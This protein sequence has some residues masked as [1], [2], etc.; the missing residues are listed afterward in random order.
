[1]LDS[2]IL[3]YD[4]REE[5]LS[6][7]IFTLEKVK[8]PESTAIRVNLDLLG[9]LEVAAFS[10]I[11]AAKVDFANALFI[12]RDKNEVAPS[13]LTLVAVDV[14]HS[15]LR[16][17]LFGGQNRRFCG[18]LNT[19]TVPPGPSG[20]EREAISPL[21]P[22]TGLEHA[23]EARQIPFSVLAGV[24]ESRLPVFFG[25]LNRA[26]HELALKL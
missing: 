2:E 26:T 17:E 18:V 23:A 24:S 6:F 1:M 13:F 15:V 21:G 16:A 7:L 11:G 14:R 5:T 4:R 12:H 25:N 3:R 22:D 8:M 20:L 9:R 10:V 19:T